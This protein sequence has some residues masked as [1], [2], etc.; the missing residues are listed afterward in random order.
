MTV[1][2]PLTAI[3]TSS[4]EVILYKDGVKSSAFTTKGFSP[5][6]IS[7]SPNAQSLAVGGDDNKIH[8]YNIS[9]NAEKAVLEE[10]RGVITALAYSPDGKYLAVGD[11]QRAILVFNCE[12]NKVDIDQWVFH[13]S[14]INSICWSPNSKRLVSCSLDTNIEVWSVDEPTKHIAIKNAHLDSA[15]NVVFL[16]DVT[17]AST[18]ADAFIRVYSLE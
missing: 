7:I 10:N 6:A 3:V 17:I 2:G 8:L 9:D 18:G 12:T 15:T 16:D 13:S 14:R 4:N 5:T 11:A 1:Q